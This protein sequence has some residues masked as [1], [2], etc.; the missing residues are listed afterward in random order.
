LRKAFGNFSDI[1]AMSDP[2]AAQRVRDAQIDV[3]VNLNGYF[4][5]PRNGVFALR[6]APVQVN[7]LGF[8]ATL[9]A[10]WMDYIIADPIVIPPD[11]CKY[12][13]EAVVWLPHSYQANDSRRPRPSPV[14]RAAAGLPSHGFVFCNFNQLYKLTPE[15]FTRWMRILQ[16]CEGSLLW[17]LRDN[18]VAA[19]NL[20]RMAI[21]HGVA[22]ERL[23]FAEV[24]EQ[25]SHLAR[26]TLAD[27]FLDTMPYNAH[28]TG[29]DAL[30]AGVPIVT[31]RGNAMPGRVAASLLTAIGLPELI[32]ENLDAY[33]ALAKRLAHDTAL[34]SHFRARMAQARESCA[35]FDTT[36]HTR[37]LETAY[38]I[39]VENS[40]AGR[41]PQAFAVPVGDA[42][43]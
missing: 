23:I 20:R 25:S 16:A 34:L 36:G 24:V 28:T 29:S 7:Y 12:Y 27:I 9:G 43:R 40:R 18:D 6:P 30:W 35:L 42:T 31:C 13:D 37:H 8:P 21:E 22:A 10:A 33:E 1:A 32:T 17:L 14:S 39:M 4:G 2:A 15:I 19:D 26:L 38:R 41:P 11:A 5:S 3:L